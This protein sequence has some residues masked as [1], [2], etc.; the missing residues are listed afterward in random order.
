MGVSLLLLILRQF[1]LP[2]IKVWCSALQSACAGF[3]PLPSIHMP[4]LQVA[5]ILYPLCLVYDVFW[6]F[7]Q[8]L[9]THSNS[10]MVTVGHMPDAKSIYS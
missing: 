1:R 5:C 6:V 8:P 2:N 7:V 10:V 9:I 4:Y 3:T